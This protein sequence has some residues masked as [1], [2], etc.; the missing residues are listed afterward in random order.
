MHKLQSIQRCGK[1][2][3]NNHVSEKAH[4]H[5]KILKFMF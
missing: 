3:I 4:V 5:L 2:V 1:G